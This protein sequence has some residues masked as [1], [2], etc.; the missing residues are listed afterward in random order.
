[1]SCAPCCARRRSRPDSARARS[2]PGAVLQQHGD[3]VGVLL[4]TRYP[5]TAF[6]DA[7]QR[8]EA[9]PQDPLGLVLGQADESERHVRWERQLHRGG[10]PAVDVAQLSAQ[11]D[12]GVQD[13][14]Q[15]PHL[16]EH[17]ERARLDADGLRVGRRFEQ[18][19]EDPARHT[20]AAQFDGRGQADGSGAGD[21]YRGVVV[22]GVDSVGEAGVVVSV[23]EL[24]CAGSFPGT[25]LAP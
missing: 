3:P 11:R 10:R 13:L 6:D 17:L 14:A 20:P 22:H 12:C 15:Y 19:I 18:R 7:A 5:R 8:G 9:V 2:C 16:L 21:D 24:R 25:A 4:E 1:M 23:P